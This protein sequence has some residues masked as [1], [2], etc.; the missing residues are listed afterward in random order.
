[1]ALSRSQ[2]HGQRETAAIADKV[3]FGGETASG[4]A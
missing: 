1:V 2:G 3:E 4:P